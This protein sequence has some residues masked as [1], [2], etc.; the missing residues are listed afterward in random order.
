[1]AADADKLMKDMMAKTKTLQGE[2]DDLSSQ[3]K[4]LM[5]KIK[6]LEEEVEDAIA[7]AEAANMGKSAVERDWTERLVKARAAFTTCLDFVQLER[8]CQTTLLYQKVTPK[9]GGAP[10]AAAGV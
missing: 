5:R 7:S 3:V 2:K 6:D 8:V 9:Q 4:L 10:T 1:M